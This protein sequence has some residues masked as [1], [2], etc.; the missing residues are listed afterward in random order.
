MKRENSPILCLAYIIGLLSTGFV[1]FPALWQHWAGIFITFSV[2]TIVSAIFM[3]RWWRTGPEARVWLVAGLIAI[4]AV[5]FF[6][7]RVPQPGINDISRK[8]TGDESVAVKVEG[9]ILSEPQLTRKQ[10]VRFWFKTEHLTILEEKQEATV[11]GKLYVTVPLLQGTGL[12]SGQ[13][14]SITGI[15]YKPKTPV[16]P[17]AF[18]FQAFLAREGAFAGLSAFNVSLEDEKLRPWGLWLLRQ[19]I[20]RAQVLWLGSPAGSLVSSMV[21]GGRAVDL[22]YDV[23]D[24]FIKSG[25]AHVLAASGFQVSLLIGVVLFLSRGFS[26]KTQLIMGLSTLLIY[27][28]LT[29][30]QPSVMR[31]GFMGI[32][33]FIGFVTERKVRPLGS[34]LLAATILLLLNPL[35]IWDLGFQLSF[36]ATLGLIVTAAALTE[37]LDFL[38]E[39]IASL[40]TVPLAATIWTLPL[41][42]YVFNTVSTYSILVNIITTPLI[43]LISLGGM[44]SA[45]FAIIFPLF[46]SAIAWLLYF[47]T[48]LLIGIVTFFTELPGSYF[49]VGRISLGVLLII[50]GLMFLVWLSNWWQ[51]RWLIA[52]LFAITLVIVPIFYDQLN[53]V[54]VTVL[55]D[56]Y[57]VLVIQDRGQVTLINNGDSDTARYTIMPFLA[58]QGINKI[59]AAVSYGFEETEW[60][61]IRSSLRVK[62]EYQYLKMGETVSVG[63]TDM[64]LISA[65]PSILE[66]NILEQIW[67]LLAGDEILKDVKENPEVLLWSGKSLSQEWLEM[68]KPQVAIAISTVLEDNTQQQL[69]EKQIQFYWTRRDGGIQWTPKKGFEFTSNGDEDF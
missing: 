17:G 2:L 52:G 32:A 8:L 22:P 7:F 29:G 67:W 21:L 13:N 39:A 38:P 9:R 30:V 64:N 42:S 37:K 62:Q 26:E 49:A 59:D 31:A 56:K 36:L 20:I 6:Q 54:Q 18:D 60:S 57:P 68:V 55:A 25:L 50:Y 15:L 48:Q 47:P 16:N 63:S 65:E 33:G 10:K 69:E 66:L 5:V 51:R 27:I 43:V 35:L 12:Y 61:E 11:T 40:F 4:L 24:I 23:R 3:P 46:G 58:H 44:L 14:V 41:T 45:L 34:L 19:R 28:G 1:G 53:L